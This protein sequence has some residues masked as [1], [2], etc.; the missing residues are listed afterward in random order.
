[1]F[2]DADVDKVAQ[3]LVDFKLRNAGQ[4]CI[5]PSRF[6][7]HDSVYDRFVARTREAVGRVQIGDGLDDSTD[8]GPLINR[9]RLDAVSAMV[10]SA[11]TAGASVLQ[12]GRPPPNLGSGY[13]YEPT[14]L[15]NVPDTAAVMQEEPFGPL[16]PISRFARFDDVMERANGLEFGLANYVFTRSLSTAHAAV[17]ELQSGMVAVNNTAVATVEGPF[18]GVKQSGFGSEGGSLG[19]QEYLVPKFARIALPEHPG[20]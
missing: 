9:Q 12:G 13:F 18:G 7:V 14:V 19:I 6:Y 8:V 17:A 2:G 1:V 5:S 11:R 16:I 3:E 10:D 20:T 15:E 4:I